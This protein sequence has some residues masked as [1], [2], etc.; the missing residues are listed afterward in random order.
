MKRVSFKDEIEVIMKMFN[1]KDMKEIEK[2]KEE[3][4][5]FI[6]KKVVIEKPIDKVEIIKDKYLGQRLLWFEKINEYRK[7]RYLRTEANVTD[8]NPSNWFRRF[9]I[10]NKVTK[11]RSWV[12]EYFIK[13][14]MV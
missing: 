6:S 1:E 11:K 10:Y 7:P 9:E 8:Y 13:K 14:Y 12:S 3:Y 5:N 4:L 2:I